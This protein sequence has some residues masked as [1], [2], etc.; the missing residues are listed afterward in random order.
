V[1]LV[2][3]IAD[4]DV[5]AGAWLVVAGVAVVLF[6]ALIDIAVRLA[7]RVRSAALTA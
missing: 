2:G 4:L 1:P 7:T 5:E 3:V 6:A